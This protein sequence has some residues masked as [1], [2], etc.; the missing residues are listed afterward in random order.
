VVIVDWNGSA[1]RVEFESVVRAALDVLANEPFE[2]TDVSIG[3][4]DRHTLS[5][6][7]RQQVRGCL[8]WYCR[9]GREVCRPQSVKEGKSVSIQGGC[10]HGLDLPKV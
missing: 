8:H 2:I 6:V 10:D 7:F 1:V 5:Q 4:Q 9:L 3:H